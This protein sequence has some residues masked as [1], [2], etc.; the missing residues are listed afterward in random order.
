MCLF[1]DHEF[2]DST[3][4][5][6]L[7]CTRISDEV[8]HYSKLAIGHILLDNHSSRSKR[9]ILALSNSVAVKD[10]LKTQPL[11]A[12][13]PGIAALHTLPRAKCS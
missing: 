13:I 6:I 12:D 9:Q 5:D 4:S 7:L 10:V 1:T 8:P 3:K 2:Y 11:R